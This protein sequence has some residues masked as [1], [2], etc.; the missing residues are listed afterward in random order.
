LPLPFCDGTATRSPSV[1]GVLADET[2]FGTQSRSR[3]IPEDG[4]H[5]LRQGF[6][7]FKRGAR[8]REAAPLTA[9]ARA[10]GGRRQAGS[11]HRLHPSICATERGG[12]LDLQSGSPLPGGLHRTGRDDSVS[13]RRTPQRRGITLGPGSIAEPERA[14][15]HRRG[16]RWSFLS[17]G[18]TPPA[19]GPPEIGRRRGCRG[20]RRRRHRDGGK[21]GALGK[22][23]GAEIVRSRARAALRLTTGPRLHPRPDAR[24][25][26]Q[27]GIPCPTCG[28]GFAPPREQQGAADRPAGRG[29][30]RAEA[31]SAWGLF[32]QP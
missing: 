29:V 10:E 23:F 27:N 8:R 30:S 28:S 16:R 6:S 15:R 2:A 21:R 22:G 26:G 32:L 18:R 1:C 31:D 4:R 3:L 9:I 11:L 7:I 12:L 17:N 24:F 20:L 14:D 5:R 25:Q 19:C 13:T